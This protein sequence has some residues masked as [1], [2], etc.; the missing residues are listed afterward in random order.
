MHKTN[1][2]DVILLTRLW[3]LPVWKEEEELYFFVNRYDTSCIIN[4]CEIFVL[5][6]MWEWLLDSLHIRSLDKD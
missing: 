6:K 1:L 4:L 5:A 3:K 2:C